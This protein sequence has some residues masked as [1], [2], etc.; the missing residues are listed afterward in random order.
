MSVGYP[1]GVAS[2]TPLVVHPT[3]GAFGSPTTRSRRRGS[4]SST[5][6]LVRL[7]SGL[8]WHGFLPTDPVRLREEVGRRGLKV[9]GHG[10]GSVAPPRAHSD[11]A[12]ARRVA[13]LVQAMGARHLIYLPEGYRDQ[14]GN[15]IHIPS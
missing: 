6:W 8:N 9:W 4:A 14:Q 3:R 1:I 15:F 12:A 13:S 7:T 10:R 11:V 2:K 5:N